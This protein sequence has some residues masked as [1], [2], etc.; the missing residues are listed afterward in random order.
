MPENKEPEKKRVHIPCRATPGC[1]GLVAV[2]DIE[3]NHD[4]KMGTE[5]AY[6]GKSVRYVCQTCGRA[7]HVNR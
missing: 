2:I 6:G 5:S 3:F 4:V 7:F 1:D